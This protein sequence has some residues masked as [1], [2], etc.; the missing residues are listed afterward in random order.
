MRNHS[1]CARFHYYGEG[2]KNI[3]QITIAHIVATGT[4]LFQTLSNIF[5]FL[6]IMFRIETSSNEEIWASECFSLV[7]RFKNCIDNFLVETFMVLTSLF[8]ILYILDDDL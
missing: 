1:F 3:L 5:K 6:E 4:D 8:Y 2:E 7:R